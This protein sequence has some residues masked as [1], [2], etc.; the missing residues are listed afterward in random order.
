ME[1]CEVYFQPLKVYLDS[2]PLL[3]TSKPGEDL[4]LYLVV[5]DHAVNVA[6]VQDDIGMQKPIHYISKAF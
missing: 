3:A 1:E 2:P 6:L 5:F 4:F